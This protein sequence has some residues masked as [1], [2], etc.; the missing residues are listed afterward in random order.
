MDKIKVYRLALVAAGVLLCASWWQIRQLKREIQQL[1]PAEPAVAV[2]TKRSDG[3]GAAT[4]Q[5]AGRQDAEDVP[6]SVVDDPTCSDEGELCVRFNHPVDADAVRE[7]MEIEGMEKSRL[8]VVA[9]APRMNY[10]TDQKYYPVAITGEFEF[11]REYRLRIRQGLTDQRGEK[12]LAEDYCSTFCR[13]DYPRS[14]RFK[15]K[16][17]RYLPPG[18]R[19]SVEFEYVNWD[20]PLRVVLRQIPPA[21]IVPLLALDGNH[22]GDIWSS[23]WRGEAWIA[24]LGDRPAIET[25]EIAEK[26]NCWQTK[27]IALGGGAGM[28]LAVIE[29]QDDEGDWSAVSAKL[30][31]LSD[32]GIASRRFADGLIVRT[33]RL[34]DGRPL[35]AEVQV[36]SAANIL[37]ASGRTGE[38]GVCRLP[39]PPGSEPLAVVATAG[40]DRSFIALD[41][42][43]SVEEPVARASRQNYLGVRDLNG[44]IW[45]E[46]AI[47]RPGDSIL[48]GAVVRGGDYCAAPEGMPLE[49]EL[50]GPGE[51]NARSYRRTIAVKTD[52]FGMIAPEPI[53]VP[54]DRPCGAWFLRLRAPGGNELSV[55]KLSVEAY[56]PPQIR[57]ELAVQSAG[58]TNLDFSVDGEYVFGGPAAGTKCEASLAYRDTPFAP[59]NLAGCRFGSERRRL[60]ANFSR[61]SPKVTGS[62]GKVAFSAPGLNG[63]GL[64]AAAVE[65]VIEGSIEEAGGRFSTRRI[66]HRFD[67]YEWY[68]GARLADRVEPEA[69]Q[70]SVPIVLVRADGTRMADGAELTVELERVD[71]QVNWRQQSAN[72]YVCD[73][74]VAFVRIGEPVKVAVGSSGEAVWKSPGITPGEYRLTAE[75]AGNLAAAQFSQRFVVA[76][77]G[78]GDLPAGRTGAVR[79]TADKPL[80]RPGDTPVLLID[81]PFTG[82]AVVTLMREKCLDAFGITITNRVTEVRLRPLAAEWMPNVDVAVEIVRPTSVATGG[83]RLCARGMA[84]L[85]VRPQSFDLP[86]AIDARYS[87]GRYL[88]VQVEAPGAGEVQ[89]MVVDEAVFQLAAGGECRLSETL[90]APRRADCPL[91]DLYGRVLPTLG[92]TAV[93]GGV[94]TGGDGAED[95]FR[96]VSLVPSR[97]FRQVAERK[98]LTLDST[99]R[100]ATVFDLNGFAGRVR[101]TAVAVSSGGVGT[102]TQFVDAVPKLVASGDGPRFLAPGDVAELTLTLA[103]RGGDS[104]EVAY[105]FAGENG[106]V[107]LEPGQLKTVKVRYAAPNEIG[108]AVVKLEVR[109]LGE[110][111]SDELLLPVRPAAP[112][113]QSSGVVALAPGERVRFDATGRFERVKVSIGSLPTAELGA[114]FAWLAEYPYGCL[115]QTVSRVYPL[116]VAGEIVKAIDPEMILAQRLRIVR[117]GVERVLSMLSPRGFSMWPHGCGTVEDPEFSVRAAEFLLQAAEADDVCRKMFQPAKRWLIDN[118]KQIAAGDGVPPAVVARALAVLA[119]C[120]VAVVKQCDRLAAELP[121]LDAAARAFLAEAYVRLGDTDRAVELLAGAGEAASFGELCATLNILSRRFPEDSRADE[122]AERLLRTEREE[123]GCWTTTAANAEAIAALAAYYG[124]NGKSPVAAAETRRESDGTI[125]N[126]GPGNAFVRWRRWRLAPSDAPAESAGL[127]ISRRY[128][129]L[130]GNEVDWTQV[131]RGDLIVAELTIGSDREREISDLVIE[132]LLP[133]AFELAGTVDQDLSFVPGIGSDAHNWLLRSDAKDDR[134]VAFSRKLKL[135]PHEKIRFCYCVRVVSAGEYSHPAATVEAMYVPSLRARTAAGRLVLRD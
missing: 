29:S 14:C 88:E 32:I 21:N 55:R 34:T 49:I 59:A 113:V 115:E 2:E 82:E 31:C 19:R 132:D 99:G 65:A 43:M 128:L 97:R 78:W 106:C 114:A 135:S 100:I 8:N 9:L 3:A 124:R 24:D 60:R 20:S 10:W 28:V 118:I 123:N 116:L 5:A 54:A 79:I 80:Y 110:E 4:V 75:A 117:G 133:G 67:A 103:N 84:T 85:A 73:E 108:E 131:R 77:D 48:C 26:P 104:G 86:V 37:I 6:L 101:V 15:R 35:S 57:V 51:G 121:Q 61:L 1:K 74:Q 130:D 70:I 12:T 23:N 42:G 125:L 16:A 72:R 38:D 39:L 62:D 69:G 119:Q 40:D 50:E 120:D 76:G 7:S 47:Y 96:R 66:V 126:S 95:M 45:T 68:V 83:A 91:Y 18:G 134:V 87:S 53:E 52:G 17:G 25:V 22:Y 63:F 27:E 13:S 94:K 64:P 81:A 30:V 129:R 98:M 109:G 33:N 93:A 11:R 89:L 111:H 90:Y 102:V 46:R 44:Y 112:W 58:M 36:F 56:A 122:L 127:S 41:E 92:A 105:Q 71:R 107:K